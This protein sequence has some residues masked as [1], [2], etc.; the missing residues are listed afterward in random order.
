MRRAAIDHSSSSRKPPKSQSTGHHHHRIKC[1]LSDQVT[2]VG[3]S[4]K[5]VP[6]TNLLN[7]VVS[8]TRKAKQ[9]AERVKLQFVSFLVFYRYYVIVTACVNFSRSFYLLQLNQMGE[10]FFESG[11]EHQRQDW[12]PHI[13]S[14]TL[15]EFE[16]YSNVSV[17]YKCK[18]TFRKT[19][20]AE[21]T[22]V[23]FTL[24]VIFGVSSSSHV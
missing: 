6:I 24:L 10:D 20:F 3:I 22:V 19:L 14:A 9:H 13:P 12:L 18:R 23:Y 21:C 17:K 16:E 2:P 7:A 5:K 15:E 4:H 1:G 11:L 8:P